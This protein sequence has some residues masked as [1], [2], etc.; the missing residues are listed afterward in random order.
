MSK[1]GILLNLE[2]GLDS[3]YRAMEVCR[4]ILNYLEDP[5]DRAVIERIIK[6]EE[7]HVKITEN[8]ISVTKSFYTAEYEKGQN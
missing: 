4:E 1:E 5:E 6:D 8:L 3:E 2:K 7:K